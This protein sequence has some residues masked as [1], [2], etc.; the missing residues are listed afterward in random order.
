MNRLRLDNRRKNLRVA[1]HSDQACNVGLRAD[2]TDFSEVPEMPRYFRWDHTESK[3][4]FKDHPM[5]TTA[6][7][8]GIPVN[9]SGTKAAGVSLVNKFRSCLLAALETSECLATLNLDV[10]DDLH[11]LRFVLAA[12]YNDA[13]RKAHMYRPD[14]FPDGPYADMRSYS[15]SSRRTT[16]ALREV[17]DSLPLL[18]PGER[19]GGPRCLGTDVFF[20]EHLLA[21]ACLKGDASH[22]PI[23]WDEKHHAAPKDLT[24]DR[25]DLRIH[26]TTELRRR[27]G[28]DTALWSGKKILAFDLVYHVLEGNPFREGFVVV[29]YNQVKKDMRMAN[30][31]YVRG[32]PATPVPEKSPVDV[33]FPFLPRGVSVLFLSDHTSKN[34]RPGR[35]EYQ[36]R[37]LTS[38]LRTDGTPPPTYAENPIEWLTA[39]VDNARRVFEESVVPLLAQADPAFPQKNEKY[40]SLLEEYYSCMTV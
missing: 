6:E 27:F 13:V 4:S 40:Q 32:E 35:F 1:T 10:E 25:G 15:V 16:E 20:Y 23:V 31:R 21:V 30:L 29:P 17:L 11:D 7:R 3:F 8:H 22:Q 12:E 36:V 37:P 2:R 14:V 34:A 26:P 33:G 38:F 24:I 28:L 5:V 18:L 9:P 19:M 39:Y